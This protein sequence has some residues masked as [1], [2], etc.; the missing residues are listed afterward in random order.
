MAFARAVADRIESM[1]VTR[2]GCPEVPNEVPPALHTFT[3]MEWHEDDIWNFSGLTDVYE[4]LRGCKTVQ[5]PEPWKEYF[6]KKLS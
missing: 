3:A 2:R 4:Y 6:P 5:I 1:K